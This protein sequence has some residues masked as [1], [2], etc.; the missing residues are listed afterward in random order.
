MLEKEYNEALADKMVELAQQVNSNVLNIIGERLNQVGT[1]TATQA[2]Q[3]VN[4][5]RIEDM[6]LIEQQLSFF[7]GK[8]QLEIEKI[9]EGAANFNDELAKTFYNKGDTINYDVLNAIRSKAVQTVTEGII[10]LSDT[11]AFNLGGNIRTIQQAYTSAINQAVYYVQ[12]GLMDYNSAIRS[13]VKNL[14]KSGI[15][16]VDFATGYSRRLD[17]QVRMNILDGVRQF[18]MEYRTQLG[19]EFGA[20]GIEISAHAL[21]AEDHLPYQGRQF[22]NKEFAQL[23]GSL[24][25]PIGTMNCRHTT[26]PIILGISQP[27]MSQKQLDEYASN[28]QQLV[29]Y[30]DLNGEPKTVTKYQA[31]QRQRQIETNIRKEKDIRNMYK[32]SGDDVMAKYFNKQVTADVKYYKSMSAEMGLEPQMKRLTVGRVSKA[33]DLYSNGAFSKDNVKIIS[34]NL[35][36]HNPPLKIYEIE[37]VDFRNDIRHI[38]ENA[39]E[40]VV[41]S[42]FY[43]N[44][45]NIRIAKTN[46]IGKSRYNHDF[47]I[48]VNLEKDYV[49][50]KGKWST[51][52]HEVGHNIDD[53]LGGV[54]HKDVKFKNALVKD[55]ENFT[56]SYSKEYNIGIEKTYEKLSNIM[57]SEKSADIHIISDLFGGMSCNMCSGDSIHQDVGYWNRQFALEKEAFAH[58]FSITINPVGESLEYVK[59]V[60]PKAYSEFIC[61]MRGV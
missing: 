11:L 54:S 37:N 58:F 12:T 31:S 25:R 34:D 29:T 50:A 51:F 32:V 53:L 28:S 3:I 4:I 61:L 27:S 16:K 19:K 14:A 13:T 20:D 23:Q 40:N 35:T 6:A 45:E 43:K 8:T 2:Q 7:S 33:E 22:S 44:I 49:N 60:F 41:K 21:C 1:L 59:S 57:L 38:A 17:S 39:P 55:F 26:F 24:L 9:I 10:N 18:N 42:I 52:F 36:R 47:G 15:Q 5:A 56:T 48:F 30:T 46:A